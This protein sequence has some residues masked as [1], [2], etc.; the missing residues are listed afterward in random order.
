MQDPKLSWR[1]RP[2][3]GMKGSAT[4]VHRSATNRLRKKK[5]GVLW[6]WR[7]QAMP[8]MMTTL[9]KMMEAD[10]GTVTV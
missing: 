7:F 2:I 4:P 10:S 8:R 5:L 6:S 3:K 9:A 1:F